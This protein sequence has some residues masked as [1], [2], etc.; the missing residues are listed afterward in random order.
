MGGRDKEGKEEQ[1]EK[2]DQENEC[3]NKPILRK[4]FCHAGKKR[5]LEIRCIGDRPRN[6]KPQCNCK[7][8]A[9]Y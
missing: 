4:I 7:D 1:K 5:S 9:S 6:A 2:D 8:G 3:I